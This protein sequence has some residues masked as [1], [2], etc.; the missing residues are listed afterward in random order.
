MKKM[1]YL[2]LLGVALLALTGC[3]SGSAE[4]SQAKARSLYDKTTAYSSYILDASK[5]TR[6]GSFDYKEGADHNIVGPKVIK[7]KGNGTEVNYANEDFFNSGYRAAYLQIFEESFVPDNVECYFNNNDEGFIKDFVTA[8][9]ADELPEYRLEGK[10]LTVSFTLSSHELFPA[11]TK[12]YGVA[13]NFQAVYNE[14]G[15]LS[16]A[17]YRWAM[18][19]D[20][21][22]SGPQTSLVYFGDLHLVWKKS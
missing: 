8:F 11:A 21:D 7:L 22:G 12:K 3:N 18:S 17:S 5:T 1:K 19:T 14:G 4:I 16:E 6:S 2:P 10:V 15:L 9:G 20:D 13:V